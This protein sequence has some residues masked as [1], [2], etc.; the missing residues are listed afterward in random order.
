MDMT[1]KTNHHK[2]CSRRKTA[3]KAIHKF[4]QCFLSLTG[5]TLSIRFGLQLRK[6][7]GRK[8]ALSFLG[9]RKDRWNMI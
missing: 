4:P 8:I 9:E 6:K 5:T 3:D 7:K 2:K 1:A